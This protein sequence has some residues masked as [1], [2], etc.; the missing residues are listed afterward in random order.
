MPLTA[1]SHSFTFSP[2]S[3]PFIFTA[4]I[5]ENAAYF[6]YAPCS[7]RA[8][9]LIF[10]AKPPKDVDRDQAQND[11]I[12]TCVY[13]WLP[14]IMAPSGQVHNKLVNTKGDT[15][16]M[17]ECGETAVYEI[18]LQGHI[19]LDWSSWMAAATATH[20]DNGS[21]L[22]VGQVQDQAALHGILAK[23]RDLGLVI[24]SVTRLPN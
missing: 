10:L 5:A 11:P 17:N 15:H 13:T 1:V 18:K 6:F 16:E 2:K 23:I 24:L 8:L 21:T 20:R 9:R 14:P 7:P 22:V 4:E 19:S 12:G 3:N